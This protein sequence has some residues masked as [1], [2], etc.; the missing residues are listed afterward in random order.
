MSKISTYVILGNYNMSENPRVYYDNGL[1]STK[2]IIVEPLLDIYCEYLDLD[3]GQKTFIVDTN[4]MDTGKYVS[5]YN[6]TENKYT[7]FT[8][9]PILTNNMDKIAKSLSKALRKALDAVLI[10]SGNKTVEVVIDVDALGPAEYIILKKIG[11]T[12][13]TFSAPGNR[14][15]KMLH[16]TYRT[17]GIKSFFFKHKEKVNSLSDRLLK[18]FER[19][20]NDMNKRNVMVEVMPDINCD[21]KKHHTIPYDI[22]DIT[23]GRC[24]ISANGIYTQKL[25]RV[26]SILYILPIN[27]DKDITKYIKPPKGFVT[28]VYYDKLFQYIFYRRQ[29][30]IYKYIYWCKVIGIASLVFILDMYEKLLPDTGGNK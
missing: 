14:M 18:I 15:K 10:E 8:R 17:S 16:M 7:D 29:I 28:Y 26:S 11:M 6:I 13:V 3:K 4:I 20:T 30:D 23:F 25:E 1:C 22:S 19:E 21:N 24:L 9:K 2:D 27:I 12:E 5:V